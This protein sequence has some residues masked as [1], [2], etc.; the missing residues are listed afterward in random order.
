MSMAPLLVALALFELTIP[1][2][3]AAA[4]LGGLA[5]SGTLQNGFENKRSDPIGG[6]NILIF[7]ST[8]SLFAEFQ[9]RRPF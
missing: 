9:M 5:F 7:D 1:A 8:K 2:M 4:W 3:S 6:M